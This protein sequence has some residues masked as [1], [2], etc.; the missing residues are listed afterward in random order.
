[1]RFPPATLFSGVLRRGRRLRGKGSGHGNQS[2]ERQGFGQT[3]AHTTGNRH[4]WNFHLPSVY[5]QLPPF[6]A[7]AAG[8]PR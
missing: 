7:R 2:R 5:T 6:E 3:E 8:L 1:L 4:N